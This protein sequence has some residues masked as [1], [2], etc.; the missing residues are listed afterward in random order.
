MILITGNAYNKQTLVVLPS[1]GFIVSGG[2][3]MTAFK[4][5]TFFCNRYYRDK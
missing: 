5:I 3:S 1:N 4:K 2:T